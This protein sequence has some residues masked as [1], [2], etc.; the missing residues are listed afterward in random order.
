MYLRIKEEE[1]KRLLQTVVAFL[2][3]LLRQDL[4]FSW[5][6]V[7]VFDVVVIWSL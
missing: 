5:E 3:P 6:L 4:L 2:C 1:R 7:S